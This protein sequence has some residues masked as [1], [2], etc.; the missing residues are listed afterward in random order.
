M[1]ACPKLAVDASS[2]YWNKEEEEEEDTAGKESWGTVPGAMILASHLEFLQSL[3]V[4]LC[5]CLA[6]A[7][8]SPEHSSPVL[9]LINSCSGC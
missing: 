7:V 3:D 9:L 1:P 5:L 8:P 4:W 2:D 6:Y